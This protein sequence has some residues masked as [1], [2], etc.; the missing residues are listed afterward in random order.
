MLFR[1]HYSSDEDG[2]EFVT[3][4]MTNV[5]DGIFVKSFVMF[6]GELIQYYFSEEGENQIKVSETERITNSDVYSEKDVSRYNLINQ[7]L[8]SNTLQD[9]EMLQRNMKQ[10]KELEQITKKGFDIL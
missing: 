10:Y 7:M 6:F 3:E 8:I 4:E 2:E 1:S 5:F 9:E